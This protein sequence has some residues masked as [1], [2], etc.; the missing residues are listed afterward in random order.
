MEYPKATLLTIKPLDC[1]N[2]LLAQADHPCK[3][4]TEAIVRAAV[5]LDPT[6][7]ISPSIR[8]EETAAYLLDSLK[9]RA[10]ANQAGQAAC[11]AYISLYNQITTES[12]L[13][14]MI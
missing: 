11:M 5:Q 6:V 12:P 9:Y 2:C 7:D 10:A 13:T 14:V 1:G 3:P 8:R 4:A